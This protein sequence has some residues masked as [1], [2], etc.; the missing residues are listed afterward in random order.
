MEKLKSELVIIGSGPAGLGAAIYAARSALDFIVLEKFMPGGQIV[1]TEFIENYPGFRG[2]ISGYELMQNIIEHC[3]DFKI[4]IK[5]NAQVTKIEILEGGRLKEFLSDSENKT[6]KIRL[7]KCDCGEFTVTAQSIII[8][9]GSRPKR[10]IVEGENEFIGKGISFCATCDGALY[11]DRE[12]MVI[13]GGNTAI[14]EALFLVKF[15]SRVHIVHRRDQLRAVKS[16]QLRA[17]SNP[18]IN[19]IWNTVVDRFKGDDHVKSVVLK[20]VKTGKMSEK[21]VDGVFEYIGIEPSSKLAEGI[22]KMDE[23]GFIITNHNMESSVPGIYAAG[24][25]RNTPLRQVITAVSDG[26][27]AATYADKFINNLY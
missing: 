2:A 22:V 7:F 8:A 13:G 10:L 5:E 24:D 17:F 23:Q 15:A 16:L 25:V 6:D 3:R 19:F 9:T 21:E 12:V 27:I 4:N 18:Q 14:Q 1:T 26:A 11:R 20:D